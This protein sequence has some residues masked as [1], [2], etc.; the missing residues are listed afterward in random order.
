MRL[1]S[2][3]T[4]CGRRKSTTTSFR[5]PK[6]FFKSF[7]GVNPELTGG[8]QCSTRLNRNSSANTI[9]FR[10]RQDSWLPHADCVPTGSH[11]YPRRRSPSGRGYLGPSRSWSPHLL[12]KCGFSWCRTARQSADA[13]ARV[14]LAGVGT[15]AASVW[16]LN[17]EAVQ[18]QTCTIQKQ[19]VR[20][21]LWTLDITLKSI[22]FCIA[23]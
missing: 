14:H 2:M 9:G 20:Y 13:P 8:G 23:F 5:N 10:Y 1:I 7:L 18:L 4:D 16:S 3:L 6:G 21:N 15:L 17:G 12:Q 19:K 11:Q 22:N